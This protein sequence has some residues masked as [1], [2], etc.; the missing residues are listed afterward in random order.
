[1][2]RRK[3]LPATL[4]PNRCAILA[5]DPGT[6][7]GAAVWLPGAEASHP[8]GFALWMAS[9]PG[10]ESRIVES[11]SRIAEAAGLP[12]VVVAETW[13][14]GGKR[15]DPRATGAMR[16]KLSERWGMWLGALLAAGI[17]ERR[18]VRV[19]SRTWQAR[20][21]GAGWGVGSSEL[22]ARAR[23]RAVQLVSERLASEALF[24]DD[25]ADA[26]C[27]AWWAR[28]SGEVAAVLPKVRQRRSA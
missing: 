26:V 22:K 16:A 11:A 21:L 20:I 10:D 2:N 1:M 3:R 8:N 19:N 5:V 27:I 28:H 15:T 23:R 6:D 7:G 24:S 9:R 17:P 18:V 14:F 4:E 12:I 13:T 25:A